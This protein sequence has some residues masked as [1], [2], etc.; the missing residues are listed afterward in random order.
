MSKIK[1]GR[2]LVV[3][4]GIKYFPDKPRDVPAVALSIADSTES[5]AIGKVL[6]RD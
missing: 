6:Y 1:K 5:S 4:S 3:R 2:A